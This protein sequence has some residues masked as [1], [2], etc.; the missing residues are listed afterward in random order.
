MDSNPLNSQGENGHL[1]AECRFCP[2]FQG[3]NAK[4]SLL[5]GNNRKMAHGWASA[6][7][8]PSLH[9]RGQ[10]LAAI[11][12]EIGPTRAPGET[13]QRLINRRHSRAIQPFSRR[14]TIVSRDHETGWRCRQSSNR[15]SLAGIPCYAGN[16]QGII[17]L[18]GRWAP[19]Q[20]PSAADFCR[21]Q[22]PEH[23]ISL[24]SEQGICNHRTGKSEPRNRETRRGSRGRNHPADFTR[25]L[26]SV[27]FG[28]AGYRAGVGRCPL[29]HPLSGFL[30]HS[31]ITFAR[32]ETRLR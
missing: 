19:A 23:E 8:Y 4:N 28:A 18:F 32:S 2:C 5:I 10:R 31:D 17:R 25:W 13:P 22:L 6:K 29:W 9:I 3:K 24:R 16:L 20:G 15:P 1:G 7:P 14:Q 11:L 26:K 27:D 30:S 21:F 12:R